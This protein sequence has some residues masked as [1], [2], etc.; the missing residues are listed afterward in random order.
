M[1]ATVIMHINELDGRNHTYASH[2]TGKLQHLEAGEV[3][4][5]LR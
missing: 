3:P 5:L 4:E 1:R 2:I